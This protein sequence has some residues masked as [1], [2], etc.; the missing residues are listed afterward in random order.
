MCVHYNLLKTHVPHVG[1]LESVEG[2]SKYSKTLV[3]ATQL[4][5]NYEGEAQAWEAL[6]K[7]SQN[8][9]YQIQAS[10]PKHSEVFNKAGA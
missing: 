6:F 7:V 8:D 1:T 10:C 3:T 2:S 9:Y 5:L 4:S